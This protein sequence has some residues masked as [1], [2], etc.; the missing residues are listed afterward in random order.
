MSTSA[1]GV[2]EAVVGSWRLLLADPPRTARLALLPFFLFLA[3]H[4]LDSILAPEGVAKVAW[5]LVFTVL[6]AVPAMLLLM[7]WLRGIMAAADPR[8]NDRPAAGWHLV[9]LQRW[10]GLNVMFY[11]MLLPLQIYTI[12]LETP[13]EAAAAQGSGGVALLFM[14]LLML[15]TYLFYGRMGM[16]LPAAAA[17]HD[18]SYLRSWRATRETGWRIAIAIL[19]CAASVLIPISGLSRPLLVADPTLAQQYLAAA[20]HALFQVADELLGAAVLVQFYAPVRTPPDR[21]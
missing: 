6:A 4:R 8:L 5:G 3:L 21:E 7:P 15:G 18:H 13:G 1:P 11:V 10:I 14:L 19:I 12:G 9:L 2:F 20:L 17:E 16:A